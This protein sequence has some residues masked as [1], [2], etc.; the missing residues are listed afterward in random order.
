MNPD[1]LLGMLDLGAPLSEPGAEVTTLAAEGG[2]RHPTAVVC[3]E[4]AMRRG[5]ELADCPR[6]EATG[7][8]EN[9]A[10][11]FH[12]LAFDP[13]AE[14][15][16]CEDRTR[17]RFIGAM[18]ETPEFHALHAET[19]LDDFAAQIA[20]LHFGNQFAEFKKKDEMEKRVGMDS[21]I[22]AIGAATRAIAAAAGEVKELKEAEG[23]LGMGAGA[24]GEKR[25][26]KAVAEA[27][28]RIRN[29]PTLR[30][31]CE[32]AGR[33]RRVAQSRQRLKAIHGFDDVVGVELGGDLARVLPH[34]LAKLDVEELEL[35]ML[36]R[37]AERQA[38]CR[39]LAAVEPVGKGPIIVTLDESGSMHS[40]IENAKGLALS[41][42]WI[43]RQQKRWCALVAYSGGSDHCLA[44]RPV[45]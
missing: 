34:E 16:P 35:D 26:P 23:M 6:W 2:Q 31:I 33:F 20:A 5:R 45:E 42:A 3:D 12:A 29:N 38:M 18:V 36:R 10:A 21:E 44:A 9:A 37:L 40:K 43:A 14:F 11:D 24:P 41:L 1:E 17:E 19:M 28:N 30:R 32:A 27:F 39:E 22:A 7:L 13:R 8:D 25:D 4:W 15:Q